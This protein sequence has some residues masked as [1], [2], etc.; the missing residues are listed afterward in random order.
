MTD[1]EQRAIEDRALGNLARLQKRL[2]Y[3]QCKAKQMAND[4]SIVAAALEGEMD[5]NQDGATF[6]IYAPP[7]G[8]ALEHTI[9]WPTADEIGKILKEI[10]VTQRK[11]LDLTNQKES[12]GL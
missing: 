10:E 5:G 7:K 12:M 11:V 9:S 3:L 4:I 8:L 6:R 1:D 2:A